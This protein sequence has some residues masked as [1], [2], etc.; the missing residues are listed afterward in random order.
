[1]VV[2]WSKKA[3]EFSYI[4]DKSESRYKALRQ[5]LALTLEKVCLF[6]HI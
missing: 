3:T 1:M 5:D 2:P 6:G 4:E